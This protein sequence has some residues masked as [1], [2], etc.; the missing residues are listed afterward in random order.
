MSASTCAQVSVYRMGKDCPLLRYLRLPR[1]D[2]FKLEQRFAG[3]VD[4]F[5]EGQEDDPLWE[6]RA[7]GRHVKWV[8]AF[9]AN[10]GWDARTIVELFSGADYTDELA[11][12]VGPIVAASCGTGN[13]NSTHSKSGDV[14]EVKVPSRGHETNPKLQRGMRNFVRQC[15][16]GGLPL[17]GLEAECKEDLGYGGP[18]GK[19]TP[20]QSAPVEVIQDE[21]Y[22]PCRSCSADIFENI[23]DAA[24]NG[25]GPWRHAWLLPILAKLEGRSR[26][27]DRRS[28]RSE[29]MARDK[30]EAIRHL[31]EV[32]AL[33]R[34]QFDLSFPPSPALPTG[35]DEVGPAREPEDPRPR[36]NPSHPRLDS[37][38]PCCPCLQTAVIKAFRCEY[39]GCNRNYTFPGGAPPSSR[40]TCGGSV[41]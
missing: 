25:Q 33:Y 17:P 22:Q 12:K 3:V 14:L 1:H 26:N 18:K 13:L 34:A 6:K 39:P 32:V 27:L 31:S 37:P 10:P 15:C 9:A 19:R 38:H 20:R 28:S 36:P 30:V 16:S 41:L 8:H 4:K 24:D 5:F 35:A 29:T 21:L 40:A 11:A 7:R 2:R 23:K